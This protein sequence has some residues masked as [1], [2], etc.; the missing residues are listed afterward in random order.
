MSYKLELP[1][2]E[3]EI[4]KVRNDVSKVVGVSS[5]HPLAETSILMTIQ[6]ENTFKRAKESK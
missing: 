4:D 6:C 5:I 2:R 1:S 3:F